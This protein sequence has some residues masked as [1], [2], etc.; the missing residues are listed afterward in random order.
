MASVGGGKGLALY[1]LCCVTAWGLAS[2]ANTVG[3]G[4]SLSG[5]GN[6]GAVVSRVRNSVAVCIG[7]LRALE[8]FKRNGSPSAAL[9]G[10][11][12]RWPRSLSGGKVGGD[13]CL[14]GRL[15]WKV[16]QRHGARLEG[17]IMRLSI[18]PGHSVD[19]HANGHPATAASLVRPTAACFVAMYG[20]MPPTPVRPATDAHSCR[21]VS[22]G[23]VG[24]DE[25]RTVLADGWV[26]ECR[27]FRT[28]TAAIIG[29]GYR[30]CTSWDKW[31]PVRLASCSPAGSRLRCRPS[32]LAHSTR[33]GAGSSVESSRCAGGQ[34]VVA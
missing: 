18:G 9:S 31:R 28:R 26:P 16:E 30:M 32:V 14:R 2:V 33:V 1:R 25:R 20:V 27:R 4:I 11:E 23:S 17:A 8:R 34:N 15:V 19:P 6:D 24:T 13:L 12:R 21:S 29:R 3:I 5:V 10:G 7:G 22:S